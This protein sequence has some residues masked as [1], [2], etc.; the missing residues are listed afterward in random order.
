LV[1]AP[2]SGRGGRRFE[3]G[4][5]DHLIAILGGFLLYTIVEW[6]GFAVCHQ[7]P[8]RSI[9]YGLSVMPL[10]ARCE[11]IYLGLLAGFIYLTIVN[12]KHESG[13]PPWWAL[14]IGVIGLGLMGLDGV[15]SYAGLRPTTNEIRV[16]TGLLAG[17]ALPLILVPMFNYQAW[18]FGSEERIIKSPA[19][20]LGYIAAIF[21]T[22][23]LTQIT[24]GWLFW[25]LFILNGLAVAFAFIYVNAILALLLPWWA[26]KAERV[27]QLLIP[28]LIGAAFGLIELGGSYF[29]HW[30]LLTKLL[31]LK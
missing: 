21:G 26:Q 14:V 28:M 17:S 15:S 10:C 24:P 18:K 22:W 5:P 4:H 23:A 7:L 30:Y 27:R 1:S 9:H 3:S 8:E 20:F 2:R 6:L 16:I 31:G 19:D 11:G 25:P 29:A 13:F 12:R